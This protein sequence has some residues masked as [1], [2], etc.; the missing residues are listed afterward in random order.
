MRQFWQS[1]VDDR[2]NSEH[3]IQT[4]AEFSSAIAV[5]DKIG[6]WEKE[7]LG[8]IQ[9]RGMHV[10]MYESYYLQWAKPHAESQVP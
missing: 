8:G 9:I 5:M 1:F 6:G 3:A 10:D 2:F 4:K 7:I